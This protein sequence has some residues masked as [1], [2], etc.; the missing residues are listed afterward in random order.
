M[1]KSSLKE[2]KKEVGE[3]NFENTKLMWKCAN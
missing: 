2:L 1:I 3:R